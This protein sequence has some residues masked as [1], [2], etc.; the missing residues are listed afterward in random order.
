[1][2]FG[3]IRDSEGDPPC[4]VQRRLIEEAGC[5]VLIEEARTTRAL[6]EAQ[7]TLLFDLK[8]GD[9][10]VISSLQTLHMTTGELVLLFRK[11]DDTGVTVR[12][13]GDTPAPAIRFSGRARPLL[14]LLADH[15]AMRQDRQRARGRIR[16][17]NRPLTRYQIDYAIELRR[18]GASLRIIG[19]LFQTAPTDLQDLLGERRRDR[20]RIPLD[21]ELPDPTD[22]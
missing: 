17:P 3:L 10:L 13:V 5:D 20:P 22:P 11:F 2:R 1:M 6:I 14:A 19:Q 21:L 15:E 12:L 16:S 8:A 4:A 18:R 9:E 7:R